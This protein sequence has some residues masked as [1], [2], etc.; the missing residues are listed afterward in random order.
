VHAVVVHLTITADFDTDTRQLREQVVPA[1][2]H[3][4]GFVAGYWTRE[5]RSGLSV[6]V[7]ESEDAARAMSENLP[8]MIPPDT[9]T[10]DG[11]EVREVVAHA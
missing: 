7:F 8:S 9:A 6:L 2:S 1:V 5:E 10:V 11:I 4:P 3:A